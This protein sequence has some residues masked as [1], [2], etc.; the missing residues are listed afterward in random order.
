MAEWRVIHASAT[1]TSHVGRNEGCQDRYSFQLLEADGDE[2]LI[3]AVSDGAGSSS[4]SDVGAETIV[5]GFVDAVAQH[6]EIGEKFGSLDANFG[7]LWIAYCREQLQALANL[8]NV[9]VREFAGT[10]LG[11]IIGR[12]RSL[13]YQLGD[14]A[15]VCSPSGDKDSYYFAVNPPEQAYVNTTFFVTDQNAEEN[16]LFEPVDEHIGDL[17]M[18]TDGIQSLAIDFRSSLPF[19][20]FLIQMLDPLHRTDFEAEPLIRTLKSFLESDR[21]CE[22]TDDDKTVVLASRLRR[23]AP[24]VT[25]KPLQPIIRLDRLL[26]VGEMRPRLISEGGSA[27]VRDDLKTTSAATGSWLDV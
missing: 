9:A 4:F 18:F 19:E 17:V 12:E 3:V 24:E 20:P 15:I 25:E 26:T 16:L 7:R 11:A 10:F 13:F 6:F 2:F 1:G 22:R 5:N 21:V 14:G 27:T 8:K 23:Y